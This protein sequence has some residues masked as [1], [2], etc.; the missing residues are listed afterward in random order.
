VYATPAPAPAPT[1]VVAMPAP[2]SK[3]ARL[4]DLL[5]DYKT[6][7]ITPAEYQQRRAKILSEP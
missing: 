2:G 1:P 6:D 3:E 4:A 7:K 5:N